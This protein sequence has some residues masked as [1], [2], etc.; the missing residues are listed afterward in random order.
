MAAPLKHAA[1]LEEIAAIEGTTPRAIHTLIGRALKKL[2]KRGL[3][4]TAAELA[5]ELD[6]HRETEN[7]V[8]TGRGRR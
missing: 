6:A 5:R 4:K 7:I 8:R 3:L 1:S 2:R